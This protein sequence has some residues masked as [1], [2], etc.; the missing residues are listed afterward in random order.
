MKDLYETLGITRDSDDRD[1]KRAYRKM[2]VQ[3]HPDKGGDE[4]KFKEVSEAYEILSDK[5][6][7]SS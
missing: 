6:K 5:D 2:A 3:H 4:Q 1:I 7:R